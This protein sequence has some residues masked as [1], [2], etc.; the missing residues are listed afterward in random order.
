[1]IS[2][3]RKFY[4][5]TQELGWLLKNSR[6]STDENGW[7]VEPII[8]LSKDDQADLEKQIKDLTERCGIYMDSCN[9]HMPPALWRFHRD[10]VTTWKSHPSFKFDHLIKRT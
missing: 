4:D 7:Y 1:M 5:K 3:W 2:E 6:P 8:N 9:M 10:D